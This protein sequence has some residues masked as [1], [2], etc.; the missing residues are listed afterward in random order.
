K[1]GTNDMKFSVDAQTTVIAA[2]AG[3]RTRQAQAAGQAGP[4]LS[5]VVRTGQAVMVNY[6]EMSGMNHATRV[7]VV[8]T[9]GSGGG[10]PATAAAPAAKTSSGTVKPFAATSLTITAAG[11]KD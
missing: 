1:V 2:G 7:Q 5:E 3:S 6:R 9:A 4:K 10:A 8:S 11:G